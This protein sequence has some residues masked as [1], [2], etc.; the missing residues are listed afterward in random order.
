MLVIRA[1]S[2]DPCDSFEMRVPIHFFKGV[3]KM[4]P[5]DAREEM[6]RKGLGG[7]MDMAASAPRGQVLFQ[8]RGGDGRTSV[9][10]SVD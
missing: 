1:R 3:E 9:V 7:I 10:I 5:E 4:L 8:F 2:A 6:A